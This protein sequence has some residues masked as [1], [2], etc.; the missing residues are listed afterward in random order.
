MRAAACG[1]VSIISQILKK[2]QSVDSLD[3]CIFSAQLANMTPLILSTT[4]GHK[5]AT[6]CLIN[7]GAT[8]SIVDVYG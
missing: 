8:K 2:A 7:N 4:H 3:E 6:I 5:E 1:H